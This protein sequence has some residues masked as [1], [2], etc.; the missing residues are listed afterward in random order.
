MMSRR[1]LLGGM[2]MMGAAPFNRVGT[3]DGTRP[4]DD[5]QDASMR[6]ANRVAGFDR[7]ALARSPAYAIDVNGVTVDGIDVTRTW[8]GGVCRSGA[9]HRGTKPIRVKEIVLFDVDSARPSSTE[10]YGE[11]FQMLSQT[12]GTLA[13]PIDYSQYTDAKHYRLP[14]SEGSRACYGLL[15]LTAPGEA[16]SAVAFTSCAKF[17]GRFD[18]SGSRIRAVLE[19]EGLE[20]APGGR[21]PLEELMFVSNRSRPRLLSDVAGRLAENHPPLTFSRPPSGWCSWYCFGPRVTA[22][23]VLDNLNAIANDVPSLKY[24]QIDDGY[25]RAMGDWLETGAAFGGDIRRVLDEIRRRGFEAAIWV[26]PFVAEEQS[27]AFQQHR[28]WFIKDETGAPLRSDRVTFGG[29]RRGPW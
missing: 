29:W 19:A 5:G 26:A 25:Q 3:G 24:I 4:P 27:T 10:L 8:D 20:L 23:Q 12:G 11:G 21:W 13:S 28:D 22:Q 1:R 17:A 14:V 15:T 6:R 18:V 2:L 9:V 7:D 16:T